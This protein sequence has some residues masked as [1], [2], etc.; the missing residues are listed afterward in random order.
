MKHETLILVLTA[1]LAIG[2]AGCSRNESDRTSADDANSTATSADTEAAKTAEGAKVE[3]AKVAE[4]AKAA[5]VAAPA[6]AAIIAINTKVQGLID[7]AQSLVA[8][9]KF[10]DASKVLNQL[11]GLSLTSEQQKLV[12][13]LKEQILKALAVDASSNTAG[14][15]GSL[16]KQ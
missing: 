7:K 6:E 11:A 12:A 13:A 3:A 2:L 16:L 1:G 5:E 8:E 15:A 10:S 4:A 14:T 9:S